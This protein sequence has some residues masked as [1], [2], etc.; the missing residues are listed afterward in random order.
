[1]TGRHGGSDKRLDALLAAWMCDALAARGT[2]LAIAIVPRRFLAARRAFYHHL[3][4]AIVVCTHEG[5]PSS[6]PN[7][8]H[9]TLEVL[10]ARLTHPDVDRHADAAW[11]MSR[12]PHS[13]ALLL[14]EAPDDRQWWRGDSVR[15]LALHGRRVRVEMCIVDSF[16]GALHP[17]SA[18]AVDHVIVRGS[19]AAQRLS[20]WDPEWRRNL[21]ACCSEWLLG[22]RHC[23]A[24]RRRWLFPVTPPPCS[25]PG[26]WRRRRQPLNDSRRAR[27]CLRVRHRSAATSGTVAASADS[28][29]ARRV[30][31]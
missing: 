16:E 17:D 25:V 9:R 20:E 6:P 15:E 4:P 10:R 31:R 21:P 22:D 30:R 3:H 2:Q 13:P 14:I 5:A 7:G 11:C 18:A 8:S 1:V 19:D 29:W 27:A 12:A 28:W 24:G 26:W 23:G